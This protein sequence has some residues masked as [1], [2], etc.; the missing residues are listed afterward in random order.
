MR[1][2]PGSLKQSSTE[3]GFCEDLICPRCHTSL[4][5]CAIF[6]GFCGT[7]FKGM[8]DEDNS[9]VGATPKHEPVEVQAQPA[10][11]NQP[12][13][14]R[15]WPV[16]I[17]LSAVATALATIVIPATVVCLVIVM[18]FLFVCPGMMLVRFLRL[19]ESVVEWV[20]AL[21][22]SFAIDA[23]VAGIL[24]YMGRWSPTGIL[25]IL[26][27]F[28]VGGEIVQLI[29]THL[30]ALPVSRW[31]TSR[32]SQ[33]PV[34]LLPLLFTV[35]FIA[36]LAAA[37]TWSPVYTALSKPTGSPS[38][39]QRSAVSHA[40]I[41]PT[42]KV[43][44]TSAPTT[45]VVDA[46]FV[47]DN[48]NFISYYDPRGDRFAAAQLFV[49]LAPPGSRVGIVK[50][51]SSTNPKTIL[52][53]QDIKSSS[54]RKLIESRLSSTFFGAVDRNPTAYFIPALQKAGNMLRQALATDRKYVIVITDELALSGDRNDCPASTD[55]YHNWFCEVNLLEKQ[56]VSVILLGFTKP[57]GEGSLLPTKQYIEAYSG[58][59]LPVTDST[60][61]APYLTPVYSDLL[62]GIRPK[63]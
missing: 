39:V 8:N 63:S 13:S 19:N 23:I 33:K 16:I 51:T 29:S 26:I 56:G 34:V 7:C 59:V 62:R 28:S 41:R 4:P 12:A 44:A 54:D 14:G 47:V 46:V 31:F 22:L 52:N 32:L 61:L 5:S 30:A 53:L 11:S 35:L 42:T 36:S 57:A 60:N 37:S 40:S 49:G 2:Q 21:A 6:C 17:I 24:I 43:Y 15:F 38:Q 9:L 50:I 45:P 27:G 10:V 3:P 18:W 48:V 20:L 55:A 1:E 25:A 58:T